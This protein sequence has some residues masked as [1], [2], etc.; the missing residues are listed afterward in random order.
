MAGE[1]RR[2]TDKMEGV[3]PDDQLQQHAGYLLRRAFQIGRKKMLKHAEPLGLS[4]MQTAAIVAMLE[5]GAVSQNQLGR[6]I[7]VEP[8]NMQGVIADLKKQNL[9]QS[10]RDTKDRRHYVLEL[11]PA[12]RAMAFDVLAARR[13]GNED[14]LSIFTARERRTFFALMQKF[15]ADPDA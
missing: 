5:H 1:D 9:I 12:G 14:I 11:T 13:A 4:P 6:Y 7:G 3:A 15:L 2:A 8:G 10:E